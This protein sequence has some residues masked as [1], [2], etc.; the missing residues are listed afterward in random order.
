[1]N[2]AY[3][4]ECRGFHHGQTDL[5]LTLKI[6]GILV[7]YINYS[8]Y[9]NAPHIQ[10]IEVFENY[11]RNGYASMLLLTLQ[12]NYP[13]TEIEWGSL[14]RDGALLKENQTFERRP[15]EHTKSFERL[16][17][18]QKRLTSMSEDIKKLT[19]EGS[20]TKSVITA[21]YCLEYLTSDLEY[22]LEGRKKHKLIIAQGE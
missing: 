13:D 18:L 1:M 5:T 10:Y 17:R 4:T 6:D 11:I 14:T 8:V 15:T 16:E 12:E 22:S 2:T 20:T 7:G 9:E 21:Y 19:D 3:H